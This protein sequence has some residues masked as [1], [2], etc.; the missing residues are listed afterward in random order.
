MA[1]PRFPKTEV[2][3]DHQLTNL[4]NVIASLTLYYFTAYF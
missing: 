2:N 1:G 4:K 3:L